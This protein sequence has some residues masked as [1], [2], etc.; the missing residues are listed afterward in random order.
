MNGHEGAD[1]PWCA[2]F[3][4][5]VIGQACD[6]MGRSRPFPST[7]SCDDLAR[8]ASGEGLFVHEAEV[9][10]GKRIPP[11]SIFLVR[12][13]PSDWPHTGTV[14]EAASESFETIEGNTNDD[15]CREGYEVCQRTRGY[16]SKDF[17]VFA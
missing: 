12:A 10:A 3:V 16:G 6:A 8:Y 5:F 7:F 11:G 9:A 15:G 17:V 4:S 2:G 1:C 14:V 13:T